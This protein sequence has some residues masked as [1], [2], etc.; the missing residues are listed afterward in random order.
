MSIYRAYDIRGVYGRDLTE[1]TAEDIGK[2]FGTYVGGGD[3]VV[4]RDCRL[5]SPALRDALIRGLSSTG[6]DV[7]DVGMVPT[8]VLYFSMV[9]YKK[10]SAVMITGSHNASEYNGFK[11]CRNYSALYGDEIQEI[12]EIIQSGD[13]R[14]DSGTVTRKEVED[15]YI[16]FIKERISLKKKLKIVLDAGNGMGG[17]IA[18]RFF[19]EVGC[20]V[21]PLYCEPDGTFP[22]HHPDPTVDEVLKDLI[23][24]VRKNKADLGVAYDGD[25]DRAGFIDDKG[26]IIRGDQSLILFS[27]E[28]LKRHR[29]AKIIF[30]VKCSQA[31]IE[32]IEMKG[33]VPIMYRT[34]H[35]FIKKKMKEENALL[36]GEMSGHFFFADD[37]Y[38]YDDAIFASARMVELLS[39]STE[40]F[41]QLISRIPRY[42][43]TPEIRIFCPEDE[44]FRIVDEIVERFKEY[45]VITVDGVRVQ[46]EDGWGLVRASNTE[47]ALILRF[48]AK[49]RERRD[50]IQKMFMDELKRFPSLMKEI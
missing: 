25:A 19:E 16:N 43:S 49:T 10:S 40:T 8:P 35:S 30:E 20:D 41:S 26:G 17:L 36:A 14:E 42:Y 9:H 5:S 32:D 39:K 11:L 21:I 28:I 37:Y 23:K 48:E 29:G 24:E 1:K 45:D 2:A 13:F 6:C 12:K 4:G 46:F 15:D 27:R 31:L 44:K 33:G 47:P 34:G 38:G 7:V 50:I 3:V 22:N 18:K